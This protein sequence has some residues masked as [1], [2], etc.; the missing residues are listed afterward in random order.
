ML[1]A[2]DPAATK[3]PDLLMQSDAFSAMLRARR[4]E[5][6]AGEWFGLGRTPGDLR[7][8]IGQEAAHVGLARALAPADALFVG[9]RWIGHASAAG[10]DP[11]DILS[12]LED[13]GL[14]AARRAPAFDAA[15]EGA[16]ALERAIGWAAATS[17]GRAVAI[18]V[19]DDEETETPSL[20]QT[21]RDAARLPVLLVVED[22]RAAPAGAPDW[23]A[24]AAVCD[25]LDVHAVSAAVA[26]A[27][28]EVAAERC[29]RA[30]VLRVGRH[31]GWSMAEPDRTRARGPD[32]RPR[33]QEDALARERTRLLERGHDPDD[34]EEIDEAAREAQREAA[35]RAEATLAAR[36]RAERMDEPS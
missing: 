12:D 8:S 9:R 7:L 19:L 18:A 17:D 30:L 35:A 1:P 10:L 31:R 2:A 13:G 24:G 34:I 5:E 14:R 28:G 22:A 16:S 3:R 27:R 15:E 29:A 36:R 21:W 33:G 32:R 11:A 6:A 20:A 25:G 23:L 4:L 26:A